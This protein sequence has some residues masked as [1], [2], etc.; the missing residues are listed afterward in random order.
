MFA[1]RNGLTLCSSTVLDI[2]SKLLD[3]LL[4]KIDKLERLMTSYNDDIHPFYVGVCMK[5][6]CSVIF[7][8]KQKI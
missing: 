2:E 6:S 8:M 7:L 5:F 1:L 4:A 3:E